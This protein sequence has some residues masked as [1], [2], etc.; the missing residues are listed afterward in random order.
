[1]SALRLKLMTIATKVTLDRPKTGGYLDTKHGVKFPWKRIKRHYLPGA[2]K[3]GAYVV[4]SDQCLVCAYRE[5][6]KFGFEDVEPIESLADNYGTGGYVISGWVEEWYHLAEEERRDKKGTY[7]S[8]VRCLSR[9]CKH[10]SEKTQRVFGNRF[11]HVFS[12]PTWQLSV[13][14]VHERIERVCKTCEG[15]FMWVPN[16]SCPKCEAV[17]FDLSTC[18]NC[19]NHEVEHDV[20]IDADTHVAKCQTCDTEWSL[21]E[22]DD[23]DFAK[24]VSKEVGCGNCGEQVYP[25]PSLICTTEECEGSSHDLYDAQLHIRKEGEKKQTRIIIQNFSIQE[26]DP[27]LFDPKYQGDDAEKAKKVAER[28]A[29]SLDLDQIYAPDPPSR[30]AELLNV[31]NLFAGQQSKR[32]H[33]RWAPRGGESSEGSEG[34][35]DNADDADNSGE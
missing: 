3:N 32:E 20:G 16:Y 14:P 33:K 5:P 22:S 13:D 9:N 7:L 28:H 19:T 27:R 31:P 29:E 35:E 17:L 15:G 11:H 34:S 4:C 18:D 21:L 6:A 23:P 26:P 10:C 1:V 25:S 2:G 8:R 30:V 12:T 24:A